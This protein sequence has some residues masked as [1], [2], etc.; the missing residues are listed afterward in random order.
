MH[1]DRVVG[2]GTADPVPEGLPT[3]RIGA[4][5]LHA[6]AARIVR[7]HHDL[8]MSSGAN[9]NA[10]MGVVRRVLPGHRGGA[11]ERCPGLPGR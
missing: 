4:G 8:R 3:A 2:R 11:L 10:D 9:L 6:I 5:C 1:I 7:D